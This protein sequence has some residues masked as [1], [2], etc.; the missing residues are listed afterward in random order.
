MA[1]NHARQIEEK[2]RG[3]NTPWLSNKI[4]KVMAERD[5]FYRQARRT[6]TEL[7]WFRYKSLRNQV[8]AMIRKEKSCYNRRI[9]EENSDDPKNFWKAVKK[10]LP[11]KSVT[12]QPSA[13]TEPI[14][15]DGKT[16][17][18]ALT[19]GNGFCTYFT[20]VV[21]KLLSSI[22]PLN[23]KQLSTEACL[24]NSSQSL[25]SLKPV[26]AAFIHRQLR[27][28]KTSKGT[29]LD[30]IPARLLKDAAPSISAPLTV[31]INLS[32]SSA[33]LP[34]EW[35]YARVVPLYK[36]GDK[37]CMDNYRPISVLPVAS[38]ILERAV[39]IQLLQ[40]LDKSSQLSPFQCGFRKNHSIQ[41]A[42]TYFTDCIR[43][44]IDEGC[45]T[46]AVFV[47]FRKAFDSV[48]HQLASTSPRRNCLG[49]VS[50]TMN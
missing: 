28:L 25:L 18:D 8:T 36:D 47:D 10:V 20:N 3:R 16:T 27:L 49:M 48:N 29:G 7:H 32:I 11:N 40:H 39:Q 22:S 17:T 21:E 4:K 34:E 13:S 9:V 44:G 23:W 12:S 14:T 38:K 33:V 6:N 43:K 45:F 37:K 50:T 1:D 46:A 30:G 19:I 41:D 26:S 24:I 35:K 15:V 5:H 2:V 31:I 42:V